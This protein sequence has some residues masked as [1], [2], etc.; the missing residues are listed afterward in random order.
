MRIVIAQP[1][2]PALKTQVKAKNSSRYVKDAAVASV[3][4]LTVAVTMRKVLRGALDGKR[5]ARNASFSS[6]S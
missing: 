5:L 1:W 4:G 3:I 2:R 6:I